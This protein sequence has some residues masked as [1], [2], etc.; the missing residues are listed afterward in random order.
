MPEL[1]TESQITS[2]VALLAPGLIILVIRNRFKGGPISTLQDQLL[3]FAVA[4]AAYYA[5][6]CETSII[7]VELASAA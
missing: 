3:A 2:V 4:S 6:A 1:P 5:A 7:E